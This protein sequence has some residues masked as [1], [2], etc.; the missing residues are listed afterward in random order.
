[1]KLSPEDVLVRMLDEEASDLA[2]VLLGHFFILQEFG[3]RHSKMAKSKLMILDQITAEMPNM[4][5]GRE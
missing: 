5:Q 2:K 1:M 3:F 4:A